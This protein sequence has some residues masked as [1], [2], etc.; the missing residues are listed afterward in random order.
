MAGVI[1]A[2]EPP[3]TAL[4]AGLS[5]RAVGE[6]VRQ[7]RRVGRPLPGNRNGCRAWEESGAKAAV[8]RP[9]TIADGGYPG[10]GLVIPHRRLRGDELTDWQTEHNHDHQRVRARVEQAFARMRT[11][12]ILRDR[13]LSDDGVRHAMHGVARLRNLALTG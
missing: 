11:R 9:T 2:S 7:P 1:T 5:P 6:L 4:F 3:W 8:G 10:T 13:R 12:K